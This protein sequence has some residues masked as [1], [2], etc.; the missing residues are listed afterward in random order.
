MTGSDKYFA[1]TLEQLIENLNRYSFISKIKIYDL[2]ME[3]NQVI[4]LAQM[5]QKTEIKKFDFSQ[6]QN[7]ISKRDSH[8]TLGAYGWKPNIVLKELKE[9]KGKV[10]WL[11]SANLIN[12]RFIFVLIVLTCKGFFSPMSAKTVKDLTFKSTIDTL[13]LKPSL[14]NKRNLTGGFVAFDWNNNKSRKLAELWAKY[15]NVEE[16]ILPK[17]SNK[18]NHRW[19]QSIL[20][21]LNYKTNYFGYLP[22]IKKIFGIKVNQNPNQDFFLFY[23]GNDSKLEKF[24]NNWYKVNK[25]ISTKTVKYSKIIWLL[26]W[27]S[28]KKFQKIFE[29]KSNHL[30]C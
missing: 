16:L 26:N 8:G 7:F 6:Y 11:D 22:K 2:G 14:L 5:S 10:I 17:E 19:D 13:Q 21:V 30:Q 27:D 1:E 28:Y 23:S 25:N 24:Y 18:F 20:T 15:S 3:E 9:N 29:R 4:S 12:N